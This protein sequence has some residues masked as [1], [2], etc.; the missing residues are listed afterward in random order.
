MSEAAY[1]KVED[2]NRA[3]D[4]FK[5]ESQ[6]TFADTLRYL[7]LTGLTIVVERTRY[8]TGHARGN[9]QLTLDGFNTNELDITDKNGTM[10][11]NNGLSTL[12]HIPG[13][14]I[15][16]IIYITN[17]VP[18]IIKLE[19]IVGGTGDKMVETA[20]NEMIRMLG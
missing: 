13:N 19:E 11:I 4:A 10:T 20:F 12:M 16:H 6:K 1:A 2:F 17:N 9:W 7:A 14:G 5:V 8:D 15:G 3:I 18:Y